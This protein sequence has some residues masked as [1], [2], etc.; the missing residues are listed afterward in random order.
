MLIVLIVA[1]IVSLIL[2]LLF[3]GDE[4]R[5]EASIDGIAILGAVFIVSTVQSINNYSQ[6]K[7]FEKLNKIKKD[8]QVKLI[9]KGES[10]QI[11]IHE[12][13]VGDIIILGTGNQVPADG[14]YIDGYNFSCDQS[15]VTGEAN[16]LKKSQ[17]DRK[18]FCGTYVATGDCTMIATAVGTSSQW[19][20]AM[21]SLIEDQEEPQETPLQKKLTKLARYIG[22][23]GIA[24]AILVF[25][26]LMI[27][28][29]INQYRGGWNW[30]RLQDILGYFIIAVAIVVMAVPEGL[31]LAVTMSLAYSL[32]KMRSDQ[33]L[34]RYL[35]ACETMGGVT[36]ICSDKTG[37]LTQNRMI[38]TKSL[39]GDVYFDD[40]IDPSVKSSL[41]PKV[42]HLLVEGISRNSLSYLEHS[43]TNSLPKY[44]GQPTECAL[45][46][47]IS[48]LNADY[49]KIRKTGS[50]IALRF[51]FSSTRKRMSTAIFINEEEEFYDEGSFR[52]YT[53]GAS[54]IVLNRCVNLI[55]SN[56]EI[57][58][59]SEEKRKEMEEYINK[60]ARNGLRTFALA[61]KDLHQ[62][63]N[64]SSDHQSESDEERIQN[65]MENELNLIGICGIE[66]KVRDEVPNAVK[67]CMKAGIKVRMITGDNILTALNIAKE[68]NI[69]KEGDIA[70]E[71]P[72][73]SQL[74]D[75]EIDDLLPKLTVLARSSPNDKLRLV[76]R[77]K[78]K[79]ELVAVTGDGT[80]DAPA[81][82]IAHIGLAMGG[83]TEVA[84]DAADII[85]L[86]DNFSSIVK[87]VVWGRSVFDNIRKFLSFQLTVNLVRFFFGFF[88]Y[89]NFLFLILI[90]NFKLLV[91]FSKK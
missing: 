90:L 39:I 26:I 88:Y 46:F 59:I 70:I 42:F 23:L 40:V 71:G 17:K 43:K 22:Y 41:H 20:N 2:G 81:L 75:K 61:F 18:M 67:E 38:V 29:G 11:S 82:K 31:P 13:M 33:C 19:G 27:Y 76:Y 4:S 89:V 24:V 49:E 44:I 74:T 15:N 63:P 54:E 3:P 12:L 79:N 86:D 10:T 91:I 57:E 69:Y 56:G 9:R 77:L 72:E 1:A 14:F 68:C 47:W 84:R 28:W 51:A 21:L 60:L 7:Q 80:N 87:A 65:E 25:V 16:P 66:D 52:M 34:V 30:Y 62:I 48:K 53:K 55:T 6:E 45:L 50:E 5:I 73:F 8:I 78:L 83:G 35:D 32:M 36:Q 37:T 58:L 85:I 64:E